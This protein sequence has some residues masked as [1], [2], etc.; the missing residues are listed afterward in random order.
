MQKIKMKLRE[1][2]EMAKPESVTMPFVLC[3]RS[4]QRQFPHDT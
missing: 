2:L 3:G 4:K 1:D